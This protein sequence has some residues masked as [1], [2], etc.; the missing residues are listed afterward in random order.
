MLTR[1]A[2]RRRR[3]SGPP[4]TSVSRS[5][6]SSLGGGGQ[7]GVD[8]AAEADFR[9]GGQTTDQLHDLLAQPAL[10]RPLL[11]AEDRV[12]EH[13]HGLIQ[14]VDRVP[15]LFRI[16]R[17]D[18]CDATLCSAS[19]AAKIR[20]MTLSRRS[21]AIRSR[22]AS[23]VSSRSRLCSSA[24][25]FCERW[26]RSRRPCAATEISAAS[27]AQ[28]MTR[29]AATPAGA[30]TG[31]SD[32]MTSTATIAATR[33]TESVQRWNNAVHSTGIAITMPTAA[34]GPHR[35]DQGQHR[36]GVSSG[37]STGAQS[38]S[39]DQGSKN[40][41]AVASSSTTL[42]TTAPIDFGPGGRAALASASTARMANG[43][44][45][46]HRPG[47]GTGYPPARRRPTPR[48]PSPTPLGIWASS[49]RAEATS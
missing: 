10:T 33:H 27:A 11:Q 4:S 26:I 28:K 14:V 24:D 31:T 13:P 38:G 22:S 32:T 43:S 16:S 9:S 40:A 20:W 23:T 17:S 35:Q 44:T 5:I 18:D 3:P 49:M 36:P 8:R 30:A 46:G 41:A 29:R 39:R 1:A 45:R 21:A 25:R 2:D 7:R 47:P 15:S 19:P 37:T 34:V 6:S 12:P 42:T 48:R